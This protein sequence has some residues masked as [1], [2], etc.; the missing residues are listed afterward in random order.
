MQSAWKLTALTALTCFTAGT[1]LA[2]AL[3]NPGFE[4]GDFSGWSVFTLSRQRS[5]IRRLVCRRFEG[6]RSALVVFQ[7]GW[8]V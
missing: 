3:V 5:W 7:N 2:T 4:S 8:T 1:T 6:N